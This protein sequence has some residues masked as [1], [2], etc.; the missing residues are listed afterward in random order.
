EDDL[1]HRMFDRSIRCEAA[2]RWRWDGVDFTVLHPAAAIYSEEHVRG[3]RA[4]KE[5]DRSCVLKVSTASAAIL[6]TGDAEARSEQE[7][8]AREPDS[9]RSEVLLV[10]HHGSKTSS[11]DAFIDAVSPGVAIFSV[12]YRNRFHHPNA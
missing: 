7:M 10:P 12:G 6:L 5:N 8:L 1:L 11:T 4:R 2:Q 9:V 3:K